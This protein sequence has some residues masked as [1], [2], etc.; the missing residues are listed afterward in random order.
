MAWLENGLVRAGIF[1]LA[2]F[3]CIFAAAAGQLWLSSLIIW[4]A[5]IVLGKGQPL[6]LLV[7]GAAFNLVGDGALCGLG[8]L[9]SADGHAQV[10]P[11]FWLMGLWVA[12]AAIVPSGF[13]W[14]KNRLWLAA[15]LGAVFGPMSYAS[16]V[17][18]G[19]LQ[20]GPWSS[21]M[22][23]VGLLWLVA[24]PVLVHLGTRTASSI[25]PTSASSQG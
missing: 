8:F 2:W 4:G 23:G 3:G 25:D 7:A 12:F 18:L 1:Q 15:V 24:F 20:L 5:A 11:P 16:G 22:L 19:A 13:G 6:T 10:L 14:L 9:L 21:S 17:S